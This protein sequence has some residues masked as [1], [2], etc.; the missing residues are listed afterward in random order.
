MN[1]AECVK[2]CLAGDADA[3]AILVRRYQG[4]VYATA[5]YYA[6]RYNAAED[7][8]QETF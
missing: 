7:I 3:Y 2:R 5:Y 4:A 1:D 8:V 6:G